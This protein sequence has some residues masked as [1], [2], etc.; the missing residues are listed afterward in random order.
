[1]KFSPFLAVLITAGLLPIGLQPSLADQPQTKQVRF[2][3]G[4]SFDVESNKILPTTFVA[5]STRK[6]PVAVVRWK[7][8]F[9]GYKPQERCNTVSQKFQKAW[10]GG[11]F[12]YLVAGTSQKTGQGII[13][14]LASQR[15]RCDDSKMLFTLRNSQDAGN[16]IA[17]IQQTQRGASGRVLEQSSGSEMVDVEELLK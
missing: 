16:V 5:S 14:G 3:C 9:A 11:R 10:E 2:Y 8:S 1:M 17:S 4:Q 7:S 13:C 6:E 15:D 12:R